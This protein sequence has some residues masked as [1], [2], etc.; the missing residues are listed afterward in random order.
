MRDQSSDI[1]V[2][3]ISSRT[4]YIP[5][6][7][8]VIT[9]WANGRL[10]AELF[11]QQ[12]YRFSLAIFDD[13]VKN[14]TYNYF[15]APYKIYRLPF[16]YDHFKGI[17]NLFAMYKILKKIERENDLLIVQVPIVGFIPLLFIGKPVIYHLCSNVLTASANR[18]KYSG[19][20]LFV[21]RSFAFLIHKIQQ[22]LFEK[23]RNRL[24]VNGEE[25]GLIYAKY[26]PLVVVSS[27][28]YSSELVDPSVVSNYTGGD[29]KILFV[30]RPSK[31][32]GI[33]QLMSAF[34]MLLERKHQV[35][36]HMIGVEKDDL[37]NGLLGKNIPETIIDKIELHGF[38]SWGEQ[39]KA[40]VS[41]CHCLVM[42]SVSEGTPRVL[43]EARA[44]GCPVIATRIGGVGSSV[45]D[46][47]DGIL[48]SPHNTNQIVDAVEKLS[49][50]ENYRMSLIKN[51]LKT[52]SRFTVETFT[53]KFTDTLREIAPNK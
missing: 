38:V 5:A 39:F 46:G 50:D 52:V 42:S 47:V 1:N 21:S 25:L 14:K 7:G 32:K 48:I 28:V 2:C 30:G 23:K 26:N 10:M 12:Q 43:I 22:L 9:D 4:A 11:R 15:V 27:T 24:I 13:P 19:I 18:F 35:S 37:L 34:R 44:L 6:E 8:E 36:L 29:F 45:T 40:T 51:G 16:P 17:R 53:K 41:Q 49:T 33:D 3:F 20:S 31:E